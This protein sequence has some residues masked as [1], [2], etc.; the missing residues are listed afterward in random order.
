ML[1]SQ[2][3]TL[4]RR[5]MKTLTDIEVAQI[6]TAVTTGWIRF[7]IFIYIILN[8]TFVGYIIWISWNTILF[9]HN[10]RMF[11][12]LLVNAEILNLLSYIV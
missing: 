10:G 7:F 6:K 8:D 12:C 4:Q 2:T 5:R 1:Y 9:V 11:W 3:L